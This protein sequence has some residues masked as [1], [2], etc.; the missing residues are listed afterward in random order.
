MFGSGVSDKV[1]KQKLSEISK[2]KKPKKTLL[3]VLDSLSNKNGWNQ[4]EEDF[5]VNT[6]V[7]EYYK[8][9]K[10][11][12]GKMSAQYVDVCLKFGR[13]VNPSENYLKISNNAKDALKRIS[14]E[15]QLNKMRMEK[16][17]LNFEKQTA[18]TN[19]AEIKPVKK[20]NKK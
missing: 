20:A 5:L 11:T 10:E 4:D 16:F 13:F 3:E 8:F 12:K 15:S 9:F 17:N 1:F 18:E 19:V 2:I 7:D 6:T 14:T